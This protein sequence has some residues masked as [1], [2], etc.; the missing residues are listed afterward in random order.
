MKRRACI[1]GTVALGLIAAAAASGPGWSNFVS[2]VQ[3]VRHNFEDL[4]HSESL[5]AVDR[6]VFSIV[7]T[8]T[9]TQHAQT[10]VPVIVI[11]HPRT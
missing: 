8:G 4:R 5:N 2:S 7:L 11:Q 6:L 10:N 3:R 9:K 1:A